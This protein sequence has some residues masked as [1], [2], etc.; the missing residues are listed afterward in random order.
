MFNGKMTSE[1]FN[2][3]TKD[4]FFVILNYKQFNHKIVELACSVLK[5]I[6]KTDNGNLV[7]I[8]YNYIGTMINLMM[9]KN[10]LFL[11]R[12]SMVINNIINS[13]LY[14]ITY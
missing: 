10:I 2:V 14:L 7:F 13:V 5:K 9:S 1:A 3:V 6:S 12:K 4:C 11:I 8:D